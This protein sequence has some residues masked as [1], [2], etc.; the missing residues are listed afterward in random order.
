MSQKYLLIVIIGILAIAFITYIMRDIYDKKTIA[1]GVGIGIIVV[2]F[3]AMRYKNTYDV[4]GMS[5]SALR[6][7]YIA[8][9]IFGVDNYSQRI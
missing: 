9:K 7:K 2:I 6:N 5:P 3:G 1:I 4:H 8:E